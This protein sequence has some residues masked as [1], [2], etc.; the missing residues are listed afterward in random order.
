MAKLG[1]VEVSYSR[2]MQPKQY[3]SASSSVKL[4]LV[5]DESETPD[6][7]EVITT[8][9]ARCQAHVEAT[10]GLGGATTKANSKKEATPKPPA[11]SEGSKNSDQPAKSVSPSKPKTTPKPK[12]PA[13]KKVKEEEEEASEP[14]FT[15]GD[16][17]KAIAATM[18]ALKEKGITDG[19]QRIQKI[20]KGYLPDDK[21]PFS[22][23]RI[24][25]HSLGDFISDVEKLKDVS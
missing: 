4:S 21:P 20:I 15:N 23:T 11:K 8:E 12:P 24:P 9:L 25:D 7:D 14:Q 13:S 17:M 2:S 19:S 1:T 22:H 10:L 18:T 5:F 6:V 3:E 16:C